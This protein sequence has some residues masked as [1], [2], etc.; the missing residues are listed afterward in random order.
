L[1]VYMR[2]GLIKISVLKG[3]EARGG[4]TECGRKI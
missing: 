3:E 4:D 2:R 1:R